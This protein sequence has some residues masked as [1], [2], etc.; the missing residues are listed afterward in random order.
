MRNSTQHGTC[1]I[2]TTSHS[3]G[4]V[5][6]IPTNQ[7]PKT[8]CPKHKSLGVAV[9]QSAGE[10]ALSIPRANKG[11]VSDLSCIWYLP[12]SRLGDAQISPRTSTPSR[13]PQPPLARQ[14]A[15]STRRTL[16]RAQQG[17]VVASNEI[18][19]QPH[20][21]SSLVRTTVRSFA[22]RQ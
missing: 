1:Q 19:G 22:I 7:D 8:F 20:L 2:R 15:W 11:N 3:I 5:S 12:T 16:H 14:V 13:L 18:H 4:N 9:S 21:I 17:Q 10:A 6:Q